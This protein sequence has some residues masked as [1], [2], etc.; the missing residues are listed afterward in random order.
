[1]ISTPEFLDG[2]GRFAN[3]AQVNQRLKALGEPL[4][5][6]PYVLLECLGIG[7]MGAVFKAEHQELARIDAVK[8]AHSESVSSPDAV[9]RF[10]REARAVA[11]LRHRNIVL[12][13]DAKETDGVRYLAMEYVEG[14]DLRKLV[15]DRG[16]L[17]IRSA[18]EYIRQAALGLQHI[19]ERGLV[20]R[21]IKPSNLLLQRTAN[22]HG[23]VE[24]VVKILD[25]GLVRFL[26]GG[27]ADNSPSLTQPGTSMGTPDYLAPEQALDA[28]TADIRA[29]LYSLG[30][31]LY[32]LLAGQVPFPGGGFPQK[33]ARHLSQS[34]E[35]VDRLR[36]DV[37][38]NVAAVVRKLMAKKPEDRFQTPLALAEE[39]GRICKGLPKPRTQDAAKRRSPSPGEDHPEGQTSVEGHTPPPLPGSRPPPLPKGSHAPPRR[40]KPSPLGVVPVLL[41]LALVA[42][43]AFVA[44]HM[45]FNDSDAFSTTG[46]TPVVSAPPGSTPITTR[47]TIVPPETGP[48]PA[49][50]QPVP[51]TNQRPPPPVGVPRAYPNS[52]GMEFVWVGPASFRLGGRNP[53]HV[54][55][56]QHQV[57]LKGFWIQ[58]T[59]VTQKQWVDVMGE[60]NHPD[61]EVK[62][63]DLPVDYVSRDRARAFCRR[64][65]E[66]EGKGREYRLPYEAEWEYAAR[67]AKPPPYTAF[68]QGERITTEQM[69]FDGR[70]TRDG[71]GRRQDRELR[72]TPVRNFPHNPVGL[73][74]M[75][76][77]LWQWCEDRYV[78]YPYPNGVIDPAC[79][80]P[81]TR[82]LGVL[83]G[84]SWNDPAED[85][86]C[87]CRRK[88]RRDRG[89]QTFGFRVILLLP[90]GA[91]KP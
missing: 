49:P 27:E 53:D 7:G 17:P 48:G 1:M 68:W 72:P 77:N 56:K 84:G 41:G 25:L 78:E 66:K 2:M 61:R 55:E 75:G 51:Q 70:T 33:V 13:Y 5:L 29:D 38:A 8:V 67:G 64:L 31:T 79:K 45:W 10:R 90:P 32:H 30:C 76:G 36:R 37:P 58:T 86:R 14:N 54:D 9:E 3:P 22:D 65:Q 88:D 15:E 11:K 69:N 82:E 59:L 16:P 87:A 47:R 74:D 60:D 42:C 21:D 62:G 40:G 4:V 89:M 23:S 26:P 63:D 24:E 28:H 20:H 91:E 85:C 6:G 46:G 57:Q 50:T 43:L 83:R 34:A 71:P 73:Y 12:V 39:L 18:C 44:W 35:P 81:D 19:H 80:G 52:V